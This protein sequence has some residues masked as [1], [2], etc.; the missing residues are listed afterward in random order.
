MAATLAY[1]RGCNS[2]TTMENYFLPGAGTCLRFFLFAVEFVTEL[3]IRDTRAIFRIYFSFLLFIVIS[4][5]SH[6]RI[7]TF[8]SPLDRVEKIFSSK[9]LGT[10]PKLASPRSVGARIGDF[11][12]D[13]ERMEGRREEEE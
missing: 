9:I 1:N 12:P 6:L 10:W 7:V 11:D 3:V 8:Q 2:P 5:A 13:T 4:F